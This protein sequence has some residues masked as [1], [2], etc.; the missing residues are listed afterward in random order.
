MP[1]NQLYRFSVIWYPPADDPVNAHTFVKAAFDQIKAKYIFQLER[2]DQSSLLHYQCY[3]NLTDKLRDTK[4]CSLLNSLGMTKLTTNTIKP[5]SA[6]GAHALS[7]YCMKHDTRVKGPWADKVIYMGQD[8]ITTLRPWQA[9]IKAM[10]EGPIHPRKV[11]W[12][13]DE[14]GGKGKSCFSKYM[15]FH[16]K[17]PTITFGDAKDLLHMVSKFQNRRGYIFDLSRTRSS[18]T[19]FNEIYCAIESI[20]NGYFINCKY[21]SDIVCMSTPHIIVFSNHLPNRSCLSQDRWS[22]HDLSQMSQAN[23]KADQ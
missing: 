9:D 19:S 5:C 4:L 18:K 6:A 21:D 16:H 13:Y 10:I 1:T 11:H 15:Y 17:I 2:G 12:Y 20:K 8:L 23:Y 22:I 14:L 7:N 3:I